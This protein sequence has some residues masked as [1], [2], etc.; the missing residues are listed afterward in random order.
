MDAATKVTST[1][2]S[3][4]VNAT[5]P[6]SWRIGPLSRILRIGLTVVLGW[7]VVSLLMDGIG[8]FSSPETPRQ[9]D[10]WILTALV[11]Y[12]IPDGLSAWF[13]RRK[14]RQLTIG[15]ATV[16]L[17]GVGVAV[18]SHGAV[19]AAPTTWLVYG[20]ALVWLS[21]VAVAQLI[22]AVIGAP[23]CELGAV[24]ELA[25][26]VRGTFDATAADVRPCVV[27]LHRLDRWEARQPWRR[28]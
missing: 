6:R 11:A 20:L 9:L 5:R 28:R 25:Q 8:R 7:G 14:G 16:F 3:T 22:S 23:G 24:R 1:H 17:V 21:S 2:P 12:G 13:G 10:F 27:G 4:P 15:V 19:W 18:A 26:R